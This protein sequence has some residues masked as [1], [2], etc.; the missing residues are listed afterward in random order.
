MYKLYEIRKVSDLLDFVPKEKR[1]WWM[2]KAESKEK[3]ELLD[4]HNKH[5]M[6]YYSY[7]IVSTKF[8]LKSSFYPHAEVNRR[9]DTAKFL[10]QQGY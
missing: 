3:Q 6:D 9:T 4:W 2:L 1:E 5:K 8:S 7:K 10:K